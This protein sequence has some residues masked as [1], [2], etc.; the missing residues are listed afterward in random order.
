MASI[1]ERQI[2]SEDIRAIFEKV[3][4][5]QLDQNDEI[6]DFLARHV[7]CH[8][9]DQTLRAKHAY[10]AYR[11]ENNLFN[12]KVESYLI[13]LIDERRAH[14]EAERRIEQNEALAKQISD[15]AASKGADQ[16]KINDDGTAK[17]SCDVAVRGKESRPTFVRP[18]PDLLMDSSKLHRKGYEGGGKTPQRFRHKEGQ[19]EKADGIVDGVDKLAKDIADL[20]IDATAINSNGVGGKMIPGISDHVKVPMSK[21][22]RKRAKKQAQK[23]AEAKSE[24]LNTGE[25]KDVEDKVGERLDATAQ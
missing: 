11:D 15:A 9:F 25:K 3:H 14:N 7:A 19:V 18:P 23:A 12:Y 5:G 1:A 6:L 10:N 21:N 2:H 13:P 22:A 20:K 4:R 8:I 24:G 17:L 16:I